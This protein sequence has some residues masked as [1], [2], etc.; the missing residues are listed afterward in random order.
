MQIYPNLAEHLR[1]MTNMLIKDNEVKWSKE[2]HMSFHSVKFSLTTA[3][4]L[5]SPNYTNDFIIFSFASE[6]TTATILMQKMDKPSCQKHF[7]V[8]I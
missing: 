2:T 4:V 8:T 5:I 1:E 3:P 7:P 6:H